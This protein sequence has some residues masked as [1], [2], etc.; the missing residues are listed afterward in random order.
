MYWYI[1]FLQYKCLLLK[2]RSKGEI[3]DKHQGSN[4]ALANLLNASQGKRPTGAQCPLILGWA[5]ETNL[6]LWA[7]L[8]PE[9]RVV[10]V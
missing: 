9:I 3:G 4:L 1:P 7:Q 6:C 2:P 8:A 10:H 5:P